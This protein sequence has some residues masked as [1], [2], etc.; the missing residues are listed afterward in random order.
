M[1]KIAISAPRRPTNLHEQYHWKIDYA[2]TLRKRFGQPE[3]LAR[4]AILK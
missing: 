4:V 2:N 3:L 1:E